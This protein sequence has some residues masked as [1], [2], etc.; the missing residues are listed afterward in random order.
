[1]EDK[2]MLGLFCDLVQYK[3]LMLSKPSQT[4]A[5]PN[6]AGLGDTK[7]GEYNNNNKK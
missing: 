6:L 3:I 5:K 2:G 4:Q 1:M 7:L